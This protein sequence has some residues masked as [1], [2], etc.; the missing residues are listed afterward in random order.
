ML[1][2]L[3]L[4]LLLLLSL[5]HLLRHL[6]LVGRS[7]F[8]RYETMHGTRLGDFLLLVSCLSLS[9]LQLVHT[10]T[11]Q[12]DQIFQHITYTCTLCVRAFF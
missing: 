7:D 8:V 11:E 6:L 2:L 10:G 1:L 5:H 4:Q 12:L 9:L 3:L